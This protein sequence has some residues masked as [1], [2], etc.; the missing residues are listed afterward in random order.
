MRPYSFLGDILTKLG[1]FDGE[2]KGKE[3]V[4]YER[5][6]V[7]FL[8]AKAAWFSYERAENPQGLMR[9]EMYGASHNL[10]EN[11]HL[12]FLALDRKN[13]P[14]PTS[15]P[16]ETQNPL[17][18][19]WNPSVSSL[20]LYDRTWDWLRIRQFLH[21]HVLSNTAE[22]TSQSNLPNPEELFGFLPP[23]MGELKQLQSR[24]KE[25]YQLA[26]WQ[27][28]AQ[29]REALRPYRSAL[30]ILIWATRYKRGVLATLPNQ[31]GWH[32]RADKLYRDLQRNLGKNLQV[33]SMTVTFR[34]RLSYKTYQTRMQR[35]IQNTLKRLGFECVSVT[36]YHQKEQ[37][38][39]RGQNEP[40]LHAHLLIW[41]SHAQDAR[42]LQ[43][44]LT[45]LGRILDKRRHGIGEHT[46][47]RRCAGTKGFLKAAA[48]LAYNYSRSLRLVR[49][50]SSNLIPNGARLVRVPQFVCAAVR[51]RKAVTTPT[52]PAKEA[53]RAATRCYAKAMGYNL[54]GR[55]TWKWSHRH[56]IRART[57]TQRYRTATVTGLDGITYLVEPY[58]QDSDGDELYLLTNKARG[59]FVILA[60]DLEILGK[61]GARCGLIYRNSRFDLVHGKHAYWL[62]QIA[63]IWDPEGDSVKFPNRRRRSTRG[64]LKT[65]D[66][67]I[68]YAG[69]GNMGWK[70]LHESNP[71]SSRR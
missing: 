19:Q 68:D 16:Q 61:L 51:W 63:Y 35:F 49:G 25:L 8:T 17:R 48:Y 28:S 47:P 44:A 66:V 15:F 60:H 67:A 3:T 31:R 14:M 23:S 27:G 56:A 55:Q 4:N 71:Q 6:L 30:R 59:G 29:N 26:Y 54:H 41:P 69:G 52:T 42:S 57:Q 24:A 62:D 11:S 36:G 58:G 13:A 34:R 39:L 65:T 37:W 2:T 12:P 38:E 22:E 18:H 9:V 45:R 43:N 50:I 46:K 64:I 53:W 70:P 40:R 7:F 10:P 20:Q 32:E 1:G 21:E 5:K 33:Y